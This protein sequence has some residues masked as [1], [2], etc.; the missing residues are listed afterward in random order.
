MK[1]KVELDTINAEQAAQCLEGLAQDLRR[2]DK[3]TDRP[4]GFIASVGSGV[5]LQAEWTEMK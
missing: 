5:N 2:Y 1:L 3:N 4:D